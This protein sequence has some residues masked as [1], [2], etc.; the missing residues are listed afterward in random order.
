MQLTVS[1]FV[2]FIGLHDQ[3]SVL[4]FFASCIENSSI[5]IW[6]A[7]MYIYIKWITVDN[8]NFTKLVITK[9]NG[10]IE[11]FCNI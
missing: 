9:Y 11:I 10:D 6:T 1:W 8:Q 7:S 5:Y 3:K 4:I 2:E